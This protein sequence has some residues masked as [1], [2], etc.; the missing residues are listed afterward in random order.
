[1]QE[2]TRPLNTTRN[3]RF[4]LVP[5]LSNEYTGEFPSNR[6]FLFFVDFLGRT[7]S[8][9][10]VNC[11]STG[12]FP[13]HL[14]EFFVPSELSIK[15]DCVRVSGHDL[16]LDAGD[17]LCLEPLHREGEKAAPEAAVAV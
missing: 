16:Q 14:H 5:P 4:I 12:R 9:K 17:V 6:L 3:K 13:H 2:M 7:F 8:Q 10:R 11:Q 1:M 15:A